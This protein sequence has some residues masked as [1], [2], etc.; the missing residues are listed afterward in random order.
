[1]E[2][3]GHKT[4][5]VYRRYHIVTE[6][7]IMDAGRRLEQFLNNSRKVLRKVDDDGLGSQTKTQRDIID[8]H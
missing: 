3:T 2:I 5:A 8:L 1:M 4:E 7:D 6:R